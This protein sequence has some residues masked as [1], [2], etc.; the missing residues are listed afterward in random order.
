MDYGD[1]LLYIAFIVPGIGLVVAATKGW[2][3]FR[4]VLGVVLLLASFG[5]T[6]W[7]FSINFNWEDFQ[8]DSAAAQ[9]V[10]PLLVFLF[11]LWLI[12][13]PSRK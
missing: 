4:P 11:G 3:T 9:Y 6:A 2:K 1:M 8:K 5:L 10:W 7:I 12:F 13:K